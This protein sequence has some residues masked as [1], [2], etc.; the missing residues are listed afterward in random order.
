ML[1]LTKDMEKYIKLQRTQ[2][3]DNVITG[4]NES[5]DDDYKGLKKFLPKECERILDIGAGMAGIDL[6]LYNHYG[7]KPELHLL[8]YSTCDSSVYYGYQ[9]EASR[10]SDLSLAAQFLQLNGVDK[11][12]I[13]LHDVAKWLK[14]INAEIIISLI[15]CGF[16]YPSK[17]YLDYIKTCKK[18]IV[19]L[20]IRKGTNQMNYLVSKFESIQIINEY[21]KYFR[22]CVK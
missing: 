8:D 2:I 14:I 10:Y 17:M 13:G 21:E 20:D 22:V 16:H 1:K 19:I 4:F 18:G 3:A 7:K 5:L 6:K 9:Q 11:K 15:S 12:K